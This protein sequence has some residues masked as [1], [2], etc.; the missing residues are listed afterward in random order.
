MAASGSGKNIEEML[1]GVKYFGLNT[2]KNVSLS[3]SSTSIGSIPSA[4]VD[5]N[6][7]F[8][9]YGI[10]N[11]YFGINV[12]NGSAGTTAS[13][14]VVVLNDSATATTNYVDFGINSSGWNDPNYATFDALAGYCYSVSSNFYLGTSGT[15][16]QGSIFFFTGGHDNK[17]F[18][19]GEIDAT[20]NFVVGRAALTTSATSG[21]LYIPTCAGAPSGVPTTKT[22]RMPLIYD[23]TNNFLYFYNSGW[24]KST[25]YA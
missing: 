17:N 18:I 21:F 6:I 14:D 5:P 19:R 10:N 8:A 2:N 1:P 24:K 16:T 22:G 23:S 20:G 12:I 3:G 4:L 11:S 7:P 9:I 13:C 15:T 25:V